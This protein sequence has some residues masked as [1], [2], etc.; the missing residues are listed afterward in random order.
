MP[1]VVLAYE[2]TLDGFAD[3]I[4]YDNGRPVDV[5]VLT[6]DLRTAWGFVGEDMFNDGE[7]AYA[8]TVYT[9][10]D[11]FV[12]GDVLNRDDYDRMYATYE[13]LANCSEP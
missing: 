4:L 9:T 6:D 13:A 1:W 10:N 5:I 8:V 11:G 3:D 7:T 12:I 2:T